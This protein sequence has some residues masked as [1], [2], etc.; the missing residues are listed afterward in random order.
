MIR[1][2]SVFVLPRESGYECGTLQTDTHRYT[3]A[4]NDAVELVTVLYTSSI[5]SHS[6]IHRHNEQPSNH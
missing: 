6:Y 2:K 1:K 4:V 3:D 5:P